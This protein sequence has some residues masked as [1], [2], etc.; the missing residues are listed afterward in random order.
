MRPGWYRAA[1]DEL[2]RAYG[3]QCVMADGKDHDGRLEF[4]HLPGR[5]TGIC[6]RG[7][8]TPQRY[9]DIKR[10]PESF[11]LLCERHHRLLDSRYWDYAMKQE[12]EAEA[13]EFRKLGDQLSRERWG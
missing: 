12:R 9:H 10:N 2:R 13:E 3:G 4:A 7:R 6:G 1:M 11:V 8:G 5:P